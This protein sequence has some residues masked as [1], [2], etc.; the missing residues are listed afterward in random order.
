MSAN[1]CVWVL[2]GAIW[3]LDTGRQKNKAIVTKNDRT[4]HD[5]GSMVGEI[6]PNIMFGESRCEG[7][8]M[9]ADACKCVGI[10]DYGCIGNGIT[11]NKTKKTPNGRAGHVF[12]MS[13]HSKK[14]QEVGRYSLGGQRG[15]WGGME[16][17][18]EARSMI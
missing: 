8:K 17:K 1:E 9:V 3:Y 13:D 15:S 10:S 4:V 11:K 2:M 14:S 16:G 7:T 18:Q 6:S 5:F 12:V